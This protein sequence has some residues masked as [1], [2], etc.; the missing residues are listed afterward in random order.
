MGKIDK[1]KE[2]IGA[3]RIYIVFVLLAPSLGWVHRN[4][5]LVRGKATQLARNKFRVPKR[6]KNL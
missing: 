3:I 5:E 2:Y 6:C 4:L 1:A